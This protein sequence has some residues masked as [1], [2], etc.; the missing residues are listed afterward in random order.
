MSVYERLPLAT[1]E[2]QLLR[3]GFGDSPLFQVLLA[4]V[5]DHVAGYALTH[6]CYS[7]FEGRGIFLE[8]LYVKEPFRRHGVAKHL[9]SDVAQ[10][11]RAQGCFGIALNV[12]RWN[13]RALTFFR[14]EGAVEL[15]DRTILLIPATKL[16]SLIGP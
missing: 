3:D 9:L 1:T 8:S 10:A 7:D 5:D 2:Q 6:G 11:A 16:S 13:S 15:D 12:L 14:N 4:F